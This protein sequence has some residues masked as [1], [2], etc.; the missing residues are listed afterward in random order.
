MAANSLNRVEVRPQNVS[1]VRFLRRRFRSMKTDFRPFLE[2]SPFLLP[3]RPALSHGIANP[4]SLSGREIPFSSLPRF[5]H[6]P[7]TGLV[8]LKSGDGLV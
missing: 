3:C 6:G 5:C 2:L 8:S 4:L 1:Y 7:S